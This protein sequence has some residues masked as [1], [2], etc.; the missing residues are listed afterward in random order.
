[1]EQPP[2]TTIRICVLGP[3]EVWIDGVCQKP[4]G[5]RISALLGLL[6]AAPSYRLSKDEVAASLWPDSDGAS[7]RRSLRQL[8]FLLRQAFGASGDV[9]VKSDEDA[10]WLDER[11]ST[12]LHA[13][14]ELADSDDV[15]SLARAH[16]LYRGF[17]LTD[18]DDP[19]ILGRRQEIHEAWTSL[20]FKLINR[21]HKDGNSQ[22]A[23]QVARTLATTDPLDE[24]SRFA[25]IRLLA[26]T[27][28][29]SAAKAEYADLD[30]KLRRD[31]GVSPS[32]P[33][34]KLLA[35]V[36]RNQPIDLETPDVPGET[37]KFRS[38]GLAAAALVVLLVALCAPLLLR[39][40]PS[41]PTE[42]MTTFASH[43]GPV[44]VE[45]AGLTE[46]MGE[47]AWEEAYGPR[48]ETWRAV[49]AP[50]AD[51]LVEVMRWAVAGD[52]AQAVRIG[53]ALERYF[54]LINR[55]S[56]W[57]DLLREALAKAPPAPS[58]A[59]ARAQIALAIASP[60]TDPEANFNRLHEAQRMCDR[61]DET[62]LRIQ[63]VRAEGFINAHLERPVPARALYE[64]AL[65]LARKSREERQI[66]LCLFCLCI[67]G[68]DPGAEPNDD[69]ARRMRCAI[70]S[71]DRF[72]SLSN[73][74]GIRASS[75]VLGANLLELAKRDQ[76][77]SIAEDGLKRLVSA[78]EQ[79]RSLGNPPGRLQNLKAATRLAVQL[80]NKSTACDLLRQ[81]IKDGAGAS[82]GFE[83]LSRLR[84]A[85]YALDPDFYVTALGPA[86]KAS[87][88]TRQSPQEIIDSVLN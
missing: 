55:Q 37:P 44:D 34:P 80:G 54:L 24:R 31:L 74:W 27:Q 9:L 17:L 38:L 35:K 75:A 60:G 7:R 65:D 61:L 78:A 69:L 76:A 57:A 73:V 19:A 40:A 2:P 70:E 18:L 1:V 13:F 79:E 48:E 16:A 56:E 71:Y 59:Y 84:V 87:F 77:K 51:R 39:R 86:P 3:V 47:L 25:L 30:A 26:T 83:K 67:M 21:L 68:P 6:A 43:P 11:V 4:P 66:A 12:D 62:F 88:A 52:P 23:C 5:R 45:L 72:V 20:S 58:A 64:R 14:L 29:L 49:I 53:G 32:L 41:S 46:Q 36:S 22:A 50:K 85:C 81:L 10:I 28:S 82:L 63:A 8:I 15:D 42:F 33:L